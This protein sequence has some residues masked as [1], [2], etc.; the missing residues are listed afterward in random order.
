M[1]EGNVF[2]LVCVLF[3]RS[4]RGGREGGSRVTTHGP[5]Q[6]C[7]LGNALPW[8]CSNLLTWD[9]IHPSTSGRLKGLLLLSNDKIALIIVHT[10]IVPFDYVYFERFQ[11]SICE[12]VMIF[13]IC[14][15]CV[16]VEFNYGRQNIMFS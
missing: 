6:T 12:K 16:C 8:S 13:C 11:S 14:Y 10:Y 3:C 7:S 5:G 4:M 9:A 15:I 2:S 1:R